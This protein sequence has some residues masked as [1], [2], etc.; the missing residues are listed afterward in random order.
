[1]VL[2]TVSLSHILR[3]RWRPDKLIYLLQSERSKRHFALNDQVSHAVFLGVVTNP[4]DRN[5]QRS[6]FCIL[7]LHLLHN[8]R[9]PP[10][11][12]RPPTRENTMLPK[13]SVNPHYDALPGAGRSMRAAISGGHIMQT[14]WKS[15]LNGFR[16]RIA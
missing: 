3:H 9:S 2:F 6:V 8:Q 14:K 4:A 16:G 7:Q 10:L 5:D 15:A 11:S 1:M 13:L 12:K